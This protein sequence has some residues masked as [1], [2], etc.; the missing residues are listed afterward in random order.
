MSL[1]GHGSDKLQAIRVG[2]MAVT[3][4]G[5]PSAWLQMVSPRTRLL[6][7][8]LLLLATL[9]TRSPVVLLAVFGLC[10]LGSVAAHLDLGTFLRTNLLLVA[11]FAA[12]VALVGSLS[13]FA[14]GE[15]LACLGPVCVTRPGVTAASLL[16]LR[17]L[18]AVS[19]SM[20][21]IR[22]AGFQ[23]LMRGFR[24]LGVSPAVVSM[25]QLMFVHIQILSRTAWGM[26]LSVRARRLAP[27]C[28]RDAY[29]AAGSHGAVLLARSLA[30]GRATHSAMLARGLSTQPVLFE[31]PDQ[32]WTGRDCLVSAVC[33]ALVILGIVR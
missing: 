22:S 8:A 17:A 27:P 26:V 33:V 15:P 28:L 29:S 20:L 32:P 1:L 5:D 9:L 12:P 3:Y 21:L 23:G 10:C 30:A 7:G 25:L 2:G 14:S 19:V 11:F 31:S 24:Q 13:P 4:G 6:G 18:A 16:L